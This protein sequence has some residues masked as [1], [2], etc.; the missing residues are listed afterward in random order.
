[1]IQMFLEYCGLGYDVYFTSIVGKDAIRMTKRY[2]HKAG[3]CVHCQQVI[4]HDKLTEEKLRSIL[5]FMY[6][7]IE[8]QEETGQFQNIK[9]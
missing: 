3:K 5:D 1:M 8:K 4:D 2:S 7:D 6:H 9:I